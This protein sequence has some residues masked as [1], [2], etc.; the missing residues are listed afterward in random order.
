MI[1]LE[2]IY[3]FYRSVKSLYFIKK[4]GYYYINNHKDFSKSIFFIFDA[5]IKI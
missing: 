4:V 2:D 1:T 5:L 3:I